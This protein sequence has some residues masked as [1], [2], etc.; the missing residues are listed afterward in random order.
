MYVCVYIIKEARRGQGALP[1][2]A[3]EVLSPCDC[4]CICVDTLEA[5]FKTP[6]KFNPIVVSLQ[7]IELYDFE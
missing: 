3:G 4:Y 6:P 2:G 7:L 1:W 5:D